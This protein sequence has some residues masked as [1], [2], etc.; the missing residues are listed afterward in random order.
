M[1]YKH[2]PVMLKEVLEYLNPQT[3][4]FFIDCTLGG[5][6]YT[7][8]IAKRVGEAGKVLAI[9]LDEAAVENARR[10]ISGEKLDNIILANENFKNLSKIIKEYFKEERSAGRFNGIVFDLGLSSAQLEDP[11]RGFSFQ[12]ADAPLDMSFGPLAGRKT[13]EIIN[14]WPKADL[15]KIIREYGEERFAKRIAA[16]IIKRRREKKI[17]TIGELTEIIAGAAP[18]RHVN[19]KIHPATRVFQALRIA[20]NDELENLKQALPAAVKSLAKGGRLAIVSFHSLEDRIVK[21]FFKE[22]ARDC[23]CPPSFPVCQCGHKAGLKI[24]TKKAVKP[25]EKEIKNNP[26]SRSARL[27]VAEK[28]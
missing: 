3:G 23:L 12:L 9:D 2:T 14:G 5:A 22:E 16:A 20:T 19:G 4:Q 21:R 11:R 13:D 10:L 1:E 26:R 18:K 6:G 15:E 17:R 24:I 7:M 28:L 27:R 8:E 25:S